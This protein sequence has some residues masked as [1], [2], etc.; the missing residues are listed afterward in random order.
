[1]GPQ[2]EKNFSLEFYLMDYSPA[3]DLDERFWTFEQM[4]FR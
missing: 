3:L 2:I 4:R 1:M